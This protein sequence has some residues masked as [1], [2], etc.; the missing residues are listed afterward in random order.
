[1]LRRGMETEIADCNSAAQRHTER[2]NRAIEVLV[3]NRVL[4]MPDAGG[5]ICHFVSNGTDSIVSGI[6]LKCI[7][8][9]SSPGIDRSLRSHRSVQRPQTRKSS[10]QKE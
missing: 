4:I 1:M 2:L 10:S 7:E 9:R 3:I 6:R 5:R 8:R